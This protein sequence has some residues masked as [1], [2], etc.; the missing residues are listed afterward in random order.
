MLINPYPW[1]APLEEVRELVLDS[2][3]LLAPKR[4]AAQVADE[5]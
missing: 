4:L 3:L 1:A 5:F 2:W